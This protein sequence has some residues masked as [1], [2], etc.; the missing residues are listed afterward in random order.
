M[1]LTWLY[2][3]TG[4]YLFLGPIYGIMTQCWHPTPE[5]RPSFA[6]LLER[7][8][9]C[10]QDPNVMNATLPVFSRPPSHERDTTV[11]RPHNTEDNCLQV[12]LL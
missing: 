3:Y 2:V 11:M 9:Y 7:L 1:I 4:Y 6:T 12:K 10:I 8:D 5:Q